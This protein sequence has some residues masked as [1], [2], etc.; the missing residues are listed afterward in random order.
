MNIKLKFNFLEAFGFFKTSMSQITF[1]KEI[2]F[3]GW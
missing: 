3:F 2:N 1:E